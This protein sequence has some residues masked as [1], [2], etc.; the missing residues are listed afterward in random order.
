[1]G[2]RFKEAMKMEYF[3]RENEEKRDQRDTGI[4]R[5][6]MRARFIRDN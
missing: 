1:M 3:K 4:E 2:Q 6:I 5:S